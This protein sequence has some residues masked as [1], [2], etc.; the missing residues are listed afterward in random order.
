MRPSD[1]S[2]WLAAEILPHERM[3]RV[4]L[5]RS[6]V[7]GLE[8]D[9]IVQETYATLAALQ[10]VDH[11]RNPRN[12]LF[13]AARSIIL[14]HVR[15][16]QVVHFQSL[17]SVAEADFAHGDPSPEANAILRDQLRSADVLLETLPDRAR[18]AFLMRR[19]HGLSQK[20]I[21]ARMQLSENTVEKHIG[22]ALRLIMQATGRVHGGNPP[23]QVSSPRN[24]ADGRDA[25]GDKRTRLAPDRRE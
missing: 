9:D 14:R 4:W 2:R 18:E 12:Y 1:R 21:A 19:V 11:I 23:A 24:T 3:L 16:A 8:I 10:S 22:K 6:R 13:Q 25:S 17:P 5:A 7:A 15:R 20:E